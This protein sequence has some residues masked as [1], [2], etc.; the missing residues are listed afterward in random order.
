MRPPRPAIPV[1]A[2]VL[3][4]FQLG[5]LK[6]ER[7]PALDMTKIFKPAAAAPA[8]PLTGGLADTGARWR[9]LRGHG[10]EGPLA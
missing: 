1:R 4:S 8:G 2:A 6:K 5:S 7:V 10:L 9:P 3:L